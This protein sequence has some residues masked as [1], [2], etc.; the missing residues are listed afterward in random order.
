MKEERL[1]YYPAWDVATRIFHWLN[2]LCLLGLI[3]IGTLILNSKSLGIS[4][5]PKILLK[6]IHVYIGY[7]F[8]INLI[9]RIIWGFFGNQY[10]RWGNILPIGRE[11]CASLAEYIKGVFRK[12][13][14][15][16]LGHN[17]LA[18][19]IVSLFF[20]MLIIEGVTGLILAGTDLYMPPF[21]GVVNEWVAEPR[22]D[23]SVAFTLTPG[24]KE[25]IDPKAYA[26]MREYRKPVVSIHVTVFYLI[27]VAIVI[28]LLG[29][30]IGEF[31]EK[32]SLI[33]AMFTGKKVFHR[34]P[35]DMDE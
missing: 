27:L 18:R 34:K 12:S 29:V 22:A 21:G 7:V 31:S 6:T 14:P 3:A 33:S 2:F 13:P 15:N 8:V 26:Q 19:L 20:V 17:P 9:I 32:S 16:Y 24:S 10:V 28:H 4:G 5:D 35:V 30:V 23:D 25:N 1:K 11:Y